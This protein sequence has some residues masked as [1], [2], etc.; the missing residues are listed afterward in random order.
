VPYDDACHALFESIEYVA[1]RM[2]AGQAYPA[3]VGLSV[4]RLR[5]GISNEEAEQRLYAELGGG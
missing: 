4:M 1:P 2:A 5:H 3:P